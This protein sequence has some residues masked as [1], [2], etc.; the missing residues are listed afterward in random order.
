MPHLAQRLVRLERELAPTVTGYRRCRVCDDGARFGSLAHFDG[1][2][3]PWDRGRSG[4]GVL[5]A[6]RCLACGRDN[7]HLVNVIGID[8]DA[9]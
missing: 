6:A 1:R 7:P 3:A 9:L 5:D 8:P 4:G 2:P